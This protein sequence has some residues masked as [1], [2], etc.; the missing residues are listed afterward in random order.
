MES[1]FSD[2]LDVML[3]VSQ[4]P[5]QRAEIT[6][7]ECQKIGIP[8]YV[9]EPGIFHSFLDRFIPALSS[10][11]AREGRQAPLRIILGILVSL[12]EFA[13]EI[14]Y[15]LSPDAVDAIAMLANNP[16]LQSF[17]ENL[18]SGEQDASTNERLSEQILGKVRPLE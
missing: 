3:K 14:R 1:K 10:V 18:V 6:A 2:I 16:E 7:E 12:P 8:A 17:I 13:P 15:P 11:A 9:L 5:G 4:N